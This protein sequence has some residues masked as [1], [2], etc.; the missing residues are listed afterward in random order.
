[1]QGKT[2]II[3]GATGLVGKALLAQL[4]EDDAYSKVK[5]FSRR[6]PGLR[7]NKIELHLIDFSKPETWREFVNGDVL[8]SALGT[9]M[10]QAGSKEAQ[11]K[12]DYTYQYQFA[13]A[14]AKTGVSTFVLISSVGADE[15][16]AFFYT[17]MKGELDRDVQ[18]LGLDRVHILR[19]GPLTGPR[20]NP[21]G[22]EGI[23]KVSMGFLNALGLFKKYK[24]ISGEEV[25]KAMR[26]IAEKGIKSQV[27]LEPSDIFALL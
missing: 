6:D 9:T 22:G 1:M 15:G 20:E 16:S 8:F 24:S 25:A 10:K 26:T 14:A 27:I 18:K 19:P 5:V 4:I 11:Y 12:V 17:K 13:E 2:A 21:R 3:I 7:S 23:L